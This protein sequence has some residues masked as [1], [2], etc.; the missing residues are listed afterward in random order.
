MQRAQQLVESIEEAVAAGDAVQQEQVEK[1]LRS[2]QDAA[3]AGQDLQRRAAALG[4][5]VQQSIT[6]GLLLKYE[7]QTR[8]GFVWLVI[9]VVSG[10]CG[11]FMLWLDAKEAAG[12][13]VLMLLGMSYLGFV[14]VPRWRRHLKRLQEEMERMQ[15]SVSAMQQGDAAAAGEVLSALDSL[16]SL[17][18]KAN[19]KLPLLEGLE[20]LLKLL[21]GM[22]DQGQ[23]VNRRLKEGAGA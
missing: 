19:Y 22:E 18:G 14:L 3:D 2:V 10:L 6:A 17:L 23:M 15:Q 16:R 4:A 21:A 5:A 8:P 1:M 12:W 7:R 13:V 20:P 9:M 11:G